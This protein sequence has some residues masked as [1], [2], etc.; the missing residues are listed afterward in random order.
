MQI[1]YLRSRGVTGYLNLGGQV[2][3]QR[4]TASQRYLLICQKLG[5]QLLTLSTR[6]LRPSAGTALHSSNNSSKLKMFFSK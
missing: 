6:H 3:M 2:V 1:S 4:A 5:G